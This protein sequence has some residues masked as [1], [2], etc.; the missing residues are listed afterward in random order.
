MEKAE[1]EVQ[2]YKIN[3][4]LNQVEKTR[5]IINNKTLRDVDRLKAIDL[6]QKALAQIKGEYAYECLKHII[7]D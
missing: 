3:A 1:K 2:I 6:Q 7:L 5:E 4:Y